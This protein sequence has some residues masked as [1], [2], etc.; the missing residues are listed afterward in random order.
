MMHTLRKPL[1]LMKEFHNTSVLLIVSAIAILAF[2]M[3]HSFSNN[4]AYG[5]NES[6]VVVSMGDSYSSGEGVENFY[7][8]EKDDPR[9]FE[10][11]DFLAHR[12][13]KSWPGSL[14]IRN[15]LNP[16]REYKESDNEVLIEGVRWFFV[17]ASGAE[18][19]HIDKEQQLKK[20]SPNSHN[21]TETYLDR[22]TDVF[23]KKSLEGEVDYVT[24]TIG[25]NDVGFATVVRS[26]VLDSFGLPHR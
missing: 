19:Q 18:T 4:K 16:L 21:I 15:M 20:H 3:F 5:I 14:K 2:G 7:G 24:I 25:G 6:I 26:A 13:E 11:Q 10:S 22:Q 23:K 1:N 17:A 9:R 12:S 8:W